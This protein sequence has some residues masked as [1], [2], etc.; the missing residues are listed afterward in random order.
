[1][2]LFVSTFAAPAIPSLSLAASAAS[3]LGGSSLDLGHVAVASVLQPFALAL[4]L[5]I[6][7]FIFVYFICHTVITK[8]KKE[9]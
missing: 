5:F 8:K 2:P 1:M 6:Y 4:P 9:K 3:F 7:L